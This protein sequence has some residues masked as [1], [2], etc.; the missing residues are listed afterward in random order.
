VTAQVDRTLA[1]SSARVVFLTAVIVFGA[2]IIGRSVVALAVAPLPL[3]WFVLAGLV[4]LSGS[5]ALRFPQFPASFSTSDAFT[6]MAA[7]LFGPAA[8]TVLVAIDALIITSRLARKRTARRQVLFNATGP[9]IAMWVSAHFFFWFAGVDPI[10]AEPQAIARVFVPLVAFTALY[11]ILNTGLTA[12]AI[13][14]DVRESPFTI[15]QRHFRDL[16]LSFFGGAWFAALVITLIYE[17]GGGAAVIGLLVPLPLLMYFAFQK[18]VGRMQQ[19]VDDLERVNRLYQ[20]LIHGAAYG[21][22]RV[23]LD[24]GFVDANPALAD[25]LG[26]ATADELK[27]ANF[28]SD[29]SAANRGKG[30]IGHVE[31]H[32]Q[33]GEETW[34]R[35]DGTR[36]DVRVSGRVTRATDTDTP[37]V[38]MMVEDVSARRSLEERLRQAEKLDALGRLAR[39]IVHDFNNLLQV[40]GGMGEI[41]RDD[42]GPNHASRTDV[43]ELLAATTTARNLT[44]QLLA[45]TRQQPVQ[46]TSLSLNQVID[47]TVAVLKRLAGAG[48]QFECRLAEELPNIFADR[49]Q[50]QQVIMNLVVNARDAMPKGGRLVITTMAL[51]GKVGLT[52]GDTGTGM[53]DEVRAHIFEPFFTTKEPGKGTGLGLAT[54]YGIVKQSG[55]DIKVTSTVGV[56]TTFS[57]E[58]PAA[59]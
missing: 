6:I 43:R 9:A 21:I 26:F 32:T 57:M 58:F 15:W 28:W 24:G 51:A 11:F 35:R 39:G 38:E 41:I 14:F 54:V 16:W 46:P 44:G 53:T 13:A 3:D 37:I 8:G 30:V 29:I 1:H 20:S 2:I 23:R 52:V 7:L 5:A 40:I 33:T 4:I 22:A 45:F 10:A 27:A 12:V 47:E 36:I 31:A 42:L 34:T 50:I 56:G 55:G 48:V 59:A 49:T 19:Q 18:A 17:R 25:M